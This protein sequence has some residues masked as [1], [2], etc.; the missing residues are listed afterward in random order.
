M[1]FRRG[2]DF[3]LSTCKPEMQNHVSASCVGFIV[4]CAGFNHWSAQLIQQ[5]KL[6]LSFPQTTN[7]Q[8]HLWFIETCMMAMTDGEGVCWRWALE[9]WRLQRFRIFC[10]IEICSKRSIKIWLNSWNLVKFFWYCF[11]ILTT[12]LFSVRVLNLSWTF[13]V[14]ISCPQNEDNINWSNW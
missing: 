13:H 10:F 8:T 4:L 2:G 11:L 6:F 1:G 3:R 9:T 7:F 12:L 5:F 14:A